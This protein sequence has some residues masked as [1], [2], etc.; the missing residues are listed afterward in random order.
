MQA[1]STVSPGDVRTIQK[2]A[3]PL[4][5]RRANSTCIVPS[6]NVTEPGMPV[7]ENIAFKERDFVLCRYETETDRRQRRFIGR[8]T[9]IEGDNVEVDSLRYKRGY[10]QDFFV[11]PEIPD[12]VNVRAEDIELKLDAMTE[13]RGR[14]YFRNFDSRKYAL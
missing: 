11:Y 14:Y 1:G 13:R 2:K 8:V 7:Q 4:R 5:Q 12:V 6:T 3:R 10:Q 9:D